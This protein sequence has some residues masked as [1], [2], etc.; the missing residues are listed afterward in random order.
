MSDKGNGKGSADQVEVTPAIQTLGLLKFGG[1]LSSQLRPLF[2][3]SKETRK[4]P[5]LYRASLGALF[6]AVSGPVRILARETFVNVVSHNDS[7]INKPL[8]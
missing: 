6:F 7:V 4:S 8:Q 1:A 5:P 2:S 3:S